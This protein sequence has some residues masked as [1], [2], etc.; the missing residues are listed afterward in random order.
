MSTKT[1]Q[2]LKLF[3]PNFCTY[4]PLAL[5][6][7]LLTSTHPSSM[8]HARLFLSN[9]PCKLSFFFHKRSMHVFITF[10]RSESRILGDDCWNNYF[11][12]SAPLHRRGC[13]RQHLPP[14]SSPRSI[15]SL[16]I[17]P[18][19]ARRTPR[20]VVATS[21]ASADSPATSAPATA[22]YPRCLRV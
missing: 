12:A 2:K 8:H 21:H 3:S 11:L 22:T 19:L 5:F 10:H 13:T 6:L 18:T 1:H 4:P 9:A 16:A 20:F 7:G 15:T 14:T 17:R